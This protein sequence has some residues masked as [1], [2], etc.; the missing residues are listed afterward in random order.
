MELRWYV[1]GAQPAVLQ[2]RATVTSQWVI[3]PTVTHTSR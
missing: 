3:V 2:W 1:D